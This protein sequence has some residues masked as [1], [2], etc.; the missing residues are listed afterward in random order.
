MARPLALLLFIF[1]L[2]PA[3]AGDAVSTPAITAGELS[4]HVRVLSK[5]EWKGRATG[6]AEEGLATDYIAAFFERLGLKP[7]GEEGT[8]FQRVPLT[9]G[10]TVDPASAM[11]VAG[12]A[13]EAIPL[14]LGAEFRPFSASATA[15][16]E[17]DA[18]FVGYGVRA[19]DLGYDDFEGIDVRGKVLFA[20]RH[21]PGGTE[22]WDRGPARMQ[23]APFTAKLAHAIERGAIALV[24]VN[25]PRSF[26]QRPDALQTAGIGGG[27]RKIPFAHLTLAAAR[28][29]FPVLFGATP[30]ELE[31]ALAAEGAPAPASRAGRVRVTLDAR[32][33]P[34]EIAGRNVCALLPAGGPDAI[35][36]IVVFGAHHDHV[37]LGE[38][39]S[40]AGAAGRGQ[41][42]NGADD[43]AS[44]TAGILEAAQALVVRKGELRRS[45][46][47]LTFTG[48]EMGLLGS[49]HFV[50]HPTVPFEK[51]VAMIN[52]DMIG[53][54][55]GR[56]L[57]VGGV[58]TSPAFSPIL[59]R[60]VADAGLEVAYGDGGLAPSDNT[61]FYQK[62]KP[63]LFFFSG[64]HADYHRPS[65]DF[66][67]IDAA[68]MEKIVR[69]A[70]EV[71]VDVASLP[72]RP[73]F[74]KSD[75]G[76]FGPPRAI[77]GISVGE[78]AK[79]VL[80]AGL[81]GGGPAQQAGLEVGDVILE[82]AGE[83]TPE[84]GALQRVLGR[85]K[86]G[87]AV[88]VKFLRG[89]E[90]RETELKLGQG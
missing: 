56:A 63:V 80:V 29:I 88:K 55:D 64:L 76:G 58:K 32:V 40:L 4:E 3:R 60:R 22:A 8:F 31:A 39:G 10:F 11:S 15:K 70:A 28:R 66:E 34:V 77:L 53:R 47:F 52:M 12:E 6:T 1:L 25:D 16:A 41:I 17:G 37:G 2:A 86:V 23:H 46:L 36:E 42:H 61:S 19:P 72:E 79:G 78:H 59:E 54:L 85:R 27:D 13:G 24:I 69:L 74:Q 38:F 21:S 75:R 51:V 26:A 14:E 44:G 73:A 45:V 18:V 50:E 20:F 9:A 49:R 67:K 71:T 62:G 68:G 5:D 87:E 30:E 35:D 43:N 83:G 65:D 89:E 81:A 7:A 90:T 57:F 48:E 82:V 33:K 84:L